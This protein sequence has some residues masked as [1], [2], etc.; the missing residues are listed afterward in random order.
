MYAHKGVFISSHYSRDDDGFY[1]EV[2]G[3]AGQTIYQTP[4]KKTVSAAQR[5]AERWAETEREEV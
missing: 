1:C 4:I 3:R 5:A 2:V